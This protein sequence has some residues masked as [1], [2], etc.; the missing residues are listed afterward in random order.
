[1]PIDYRNYPHNWHSEIRP[2]ILERAQN[3]CE[4]CGVPNYAF[5]IRGYDGRFYDA[6]T[7]EDCIATIQGLADL[8]APYIRIILTIAHLDHD[9]TNNDHGNLAALCQRCHNRYDAPHR[10]RNAAATRRRNW[11]A[12]SGQMD[13]FEE[14]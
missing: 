6:E 11:V 3:R 4:R 12:A 1:M 10:A 2:R 14:E 13:M 8:D 9:T 5:G 7:E